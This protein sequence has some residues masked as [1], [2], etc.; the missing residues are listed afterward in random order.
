MQQDDGRS[1]ADVGDIETQLSDSDTSFKNVEIGH[2]RTIAIRTLP[3]LGEEFACAV[4]TF[5]GALRC[6]GS[7]Y[8][9]KST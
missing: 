4:I 9:L 2:W 7:Q 8:F 3:R 5:I 1:N 6:S